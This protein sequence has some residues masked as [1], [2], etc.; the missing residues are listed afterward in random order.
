MY[1]YNPSACWHK[2]HEIWHFQDEKSDDQKAEKKAE[3]VEI[4]V[5]NEITGAELFTRMGVETYMDLRMMIGNRLDM[6]ATYVTHNIEMILDGNLLVPKDGNWSALL[7]FTTN[8]TVGYILKPYVCE[9]CHAYVNTDNDVEVWQCEDCNKCFHHTCAPNHPNADMQTVCDQCAC[10]W[11]EGLKKE[12]E[13]KEVKKSKDAK[14]KKAE[15]AMLEGS[16]SWRKR[17]ARRRMRS[18]RMRSSRIGLGMETFSRNAR[19]ATRLG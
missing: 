18:R 1:I 17:L 16:L 2:F 14:S 15:K 9:V 3:R 6:D 12:E 4:T 5:K 11:K 8:T 7:G 13:E 19:F 10:D